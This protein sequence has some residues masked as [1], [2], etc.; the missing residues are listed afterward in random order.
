[1]IS[2]IMKTGVVRWEGGDGR[3]LQRPVNV[4]YMTDVCKAI[5]GSETRKQRIEAAHEHRDNKRATAGLS[6]EYAKRDAK[7]AAKRV[8]N[9]KALAQIMRNLATPQEKVFTTGPEL[10]VAFWT[11]IAPLLLIGLAM[12]S[13]EVAPSI[14]RIVSSTTNNPS[15]AKVERLMM[16]WLVGKRRTNNADRV[17]RFRERRLQAEQAA[18]EANRAVNF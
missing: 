8:Q 5:L 9:A 3:A 2:I 16:D 18:Y 12:D 13:T 14:K 6:A 4:E 1:M 15:A 7:I 17:R 11:R 10:W